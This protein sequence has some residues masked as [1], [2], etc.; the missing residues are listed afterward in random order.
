MINR[1]II[2]WNGHASKRESGLILPAANLM[3]LYSKEEYI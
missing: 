1:R 3:S 2:P